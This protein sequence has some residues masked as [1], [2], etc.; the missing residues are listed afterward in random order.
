MCSDLAM[1]YLDTAAAWHEDLSISA[2]TE[3]AADA[4]THTP[5]SFEL[6]LNPGHLLRLAEWMRNPFVSSD[7]TVF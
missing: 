5:K 2:T 3:Y 7:R 6:C 4:V 1:N